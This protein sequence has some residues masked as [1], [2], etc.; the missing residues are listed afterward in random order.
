[1]SLFRRVVLSISTGLVFLLGCGGGGGGSSSPVI[2]APS[3]LAYS[4]NPAIYTIGTAIPT[5]NSPTS[6]GGAVASYSVNPSLPAGLS[7]NASTGVITGV[8]AAITPPATY[9]VTA[10]N[11]TGSAN[12]G[13][14]ITVNDAIPSNLTYSTNPATYTIGTPIPSPNSPAS[15]GGAVVSY[16]VNPSLPLGLSMNTSTG[17]ITGIPTVLT[18]SAT[19]TVTATNTGGRATATLTLEVLAAL[20]AL[21]PLQQLLPV[22]TTVVLAPTVIGGAPPYAYTWARNGATIPGA[23]RAT[24]TIP[25]LNLSDQATYQVTVRDSLA[26]SNLASTKLFVA[27]TA[28]LGASSP[29]SAKPLAATAA[30]AS[31]SVN[32]VGVVATAG[33]IYLTSPGTSRVLALSRTT[34]ERQSILLPAGSA[35]TGI[36][37]D[38]SGNPWVTLN[39]TGQIV[40]IDASTATVGAPIA[41]GGQPYGITRGPNNDLWFTLQ[42]T[43]QIGRVTPEGGTPTLYGL[44]SGASPAGIFVATD[45][46]VWF[47]ERALG[48]VGRLAPGSTTV[49][50]WACAHQNA[51]PEQILV[52]GGQVFYTDQNSAALVVFPAGT[53]VPGTGTLNQAYAYGTNPQGGAAGIALDASGNVWL[54]QQ[55]NGQVTRLNPTTGETYLYTLP[56]SQSQPT[57]ITVAADG[58]VWVTLTGTN[59]IAQI[60]L[61]P[62]S[63]TVV[64]NAAEPKRALKGETLAYTV[65]VTGATDASIIWELLE[66]ASAG[67]I[68]QGGVYTATTTPGRY[69]VIARSVQDPSK[70]GRLE[71]VVYPWT[72]WPSGQLTSLAG[73]L[74]GAGSV[75]GLAGNARFSW[76]SHAAV[77]PSGNI[78]ITDWQNHTIRK[79]AP[80]GQVTTVAGKL[81][82][83][84]SADGYGQ[85]A[86][87]QDLRGIVS[88]S[89]GNLYIAD[90]ASHTIRKMTPDG[91]VTTFAGSPGQRGTADGSGSNARFNKPYGLAI[92][93][94]GVLYVADSANH[95]IRTITP[96]G[97]VST[98]AGMPGLYGHHDGPAAITTFWGPSGL[99]V[100]ATG[101]V[102]V[103]DCYNSAIRKIGKDGQV[104]TLAGNAP[105]QG[106]ADG[107]GASATFIHP[108]SIAIDPSGNLLVTDSFNNTIRKV[109]LSGDVTTLAGMAGQTGS[110]DG[111]GA[112]ARFY[113]PIDISLDA[114]GNAIIVDAGNCTIRKLTPTGAVTTLAGCASQLGDALG[115]GPQAL[116]NGTYGLALSGSGTVY[117]ADSINAKVKQVSALGVVS[118]LGNSDLLVSPAGLGINSAGHVFVADY[119]ACWITEISPTGAEAIF[120][121]QNAGY[122]HG[123]LDGPAASA[124]FDSPLGTAVDSAGNVYVADAANRR[125]RKITPSGTVSTFAGSGI[126]AGVD[127]VG[128]A[129]SFMAPVALAFDASGN[130]YVCDSFVIR[131]ILPNGTVSTL[132]GAYG[133]PGVED[134]P[135]QSARLSYPYGCAVDAVGRI[136]FTEI[137]T[138]TIRVITPEGFVATLIGDASFGIGRPGKLRDGAD[139][140]L[141]SGYAS[142]ANPTSIAVSPDGSLLYITGGNGIAK[143]AITW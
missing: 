67:S 135:L 73:D 40:K 99:A 86:R 111:E 30:T 14:V 124:Q 95:T 143:V 113:S 11:A 136:Y 104:T 74:D 78:W 108:Y 31:D 58:S 33:Y 48:K 69:H 41:V 76:A 117:V 123:F 65:T 15:G 37:L 139:L 62:P 118:L 32:P 132:V 7:F 43:D 50:E 92:D 131:K 71:V 84:G 26:A 109:T 72:R 12:V 116:F 3:A 96:G 141:S 137:L 128:V 103:A 6:G 9:T 13:L 21:L 130:L 94:A 42:G 115:S 64:I 38:G 44:S 49:D 80:S 63:I 122:I 20:G 127:G 29:G 45:G 129:A 77:D 97:R 16:S 114:G 120:A 36:T 88:D 51:R 134:G 121:G 17:I 107:N 89:A 27:T 142:I 68:T 66:G 10:T 28:S 54:T 106:S 56:S 91:N 75:D 105:H 119:G 98:L 140:P 60:P 133:Q 57:G 90:S 5:P 125:I 100:D 83:Q 1:M 19:Y 25:F 138:N 81:G 24:Y 85:N 101:I 93:S 35:P 23:T 4:T 70:F 79:L 55:G 18:P 34:G 102:Y 126:K 87:F 52:A 2:Q 82:L 59:E 39:A 47:T 110:A 8:P 22:T 46:T 53:Q 112:A 61:A